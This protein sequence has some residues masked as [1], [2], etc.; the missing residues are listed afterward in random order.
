MVECQRNQFIL[1][2]HTVEN[3]I[4]LKFE[5]E[6]LSRP[7]GFG[8]QC[9][10][11]FGTLIPLTSEEESAQLFMLWYKTKDC[12]KGRIQGTFWFRV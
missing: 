6:I 5:L 7:A 12:V 3:Q 4:K 11:S 2:A 9:T 10:H 8:R 1:K